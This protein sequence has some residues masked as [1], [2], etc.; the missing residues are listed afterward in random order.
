MLLNICERYTH[1]GPLVV[2]NMT[3]IRVSGEW[4]VDGF[5]KALD[6][7]TKNVSFYF[8]RLPLKEN[9]YFSLGLVSRIRGSL[10]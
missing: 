8:G 7:S 10:C 9:L 1:T 6:I 2:T 3:M 4:W 5:I